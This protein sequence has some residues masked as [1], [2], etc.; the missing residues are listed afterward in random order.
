MCSLLD[1]TCYLTKIPN[2]L[3]TQHKLLF[4]NKDEEHFL[5]YEG[6]DAQDQ[7]AGR[8]C[9]CPIS[10][11]VQGQVGWSFEQPGLVEKCPCPW[12]G[13]GN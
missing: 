10:G 3:F 13:G 9:G 6:G 2:Y 5:Y 4:R 11:T 7:V 1:C 8:S 12:Q